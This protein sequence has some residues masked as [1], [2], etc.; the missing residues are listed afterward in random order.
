MCQSD[1]HA[2]GSMMMANAAIGA[3]GQYAAGKVNAQNAMTKATFEASMLESMG[4]I[5]DARK[6]QGEANI[7]MSMSTQIQNNIAQAMLSGLDMSSFNSID[8]GMR[9]DTTEALSKL[10]ANTRMEKLNLRNKSAMAMLGGQMDAAAFR[11]RG[12]LGAL[13]TLNE[14]YQTYEDTKHGDTMPRGEWRK[15]KYQQAKSFLTSK[16]RIG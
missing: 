14:G 3:Y 6:F 11:M 15:Q 2:K 8:K 16:M 4:V 5:A 9:K 13:K 10:D 7:R 1:S 12:N